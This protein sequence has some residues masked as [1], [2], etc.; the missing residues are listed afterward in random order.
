MEDVE[1]LMEQLDKKEIE[2]VNNMIN[3]TRHNKYRRRPTQQ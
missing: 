3:L 1:H 2:D